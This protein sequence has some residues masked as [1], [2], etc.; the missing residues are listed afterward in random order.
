MRGD[1]TS[2]PLD[3]S[4]FHELRRLTQRANAGDPTALTRMREILEVTPR[5][6]QHVGDVAS[7]AERAWVALLAGKDT[8]GAESIRRKA[9]E[10]RRELEGEHPTAIERMLV[11]QVVVNWLEMAH[12]QAGATQEGGPVSQA[13]H[14][15]RR[16]ETAQRKYT[17]AIKALTQVRTLL[18]RGLVPSNA[19]LRLHDGRETA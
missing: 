4:I 8:L 6:W 2:E 11:D 14:R 17:A 7:Q 12:A 5:I 10:L 15:L 1:D 13:N 16:A 9:A 19:T 3:S 18:A